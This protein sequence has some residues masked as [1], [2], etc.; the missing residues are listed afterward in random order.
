MASILPAINMHHALEIANSVDYGL[1][2][3]VFTRDINKALFVARNIEVG[4]FFINTAC[5][6]AE[7]QLPFGG[8][9]GS[10]NGRREGAHHMLDI[11]TEWK[12]VAIQGEAP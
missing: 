1:T 2:S 8:R 11:Y 6:G 9:K 3:A 10:G 12:T 5:V 7:I 4:S